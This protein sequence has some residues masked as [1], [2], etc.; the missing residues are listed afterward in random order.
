MAVHK[1]AVMKLLVTPLTT[2]KS[3]FIMKLCHWVKHYTFITCNLM[4][5]GVISNSGLL[6]VALWLFYSRVSLRI[7]MCPSHRSVFRR[8]SYECTCRT[9]LKGLF[10]NL[11]DDLFSYILLQRWPIPTHTLIIISVVD[12]TW[13]KYHHL[14]WIPSDTEWHIKN[15]TQYI[16]KNLFTKHCSI[17]MF[18]MING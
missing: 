3:S 1:L 10:S 8:P 15:I 2:A 13:H 9:K 6:L 17:H 4:R 16:L 7:L 5:R 11:C 18:L 14:V 12:L